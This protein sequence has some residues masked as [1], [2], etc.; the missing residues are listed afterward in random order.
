MDLQGFLEPACR[1]TV[2]GLGAVQYLE[3][4][5]LDASFEESVAADGA[6]H[7]EVPLTTGAWRTL[8]YL[9]GTGSWTEQMARSVQGAHY[10]VRIQLSLQGD[11]PEHRE[12]VSRMKGRRFLLRVPANN[13]DGLLIGTAERP[14]RFESA[15][16]S[17]SDDG[18][19]RQQTLT[20]SGVAL[21]PSPAYTPTF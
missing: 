5:R 19:S 12:E 17:G 10:A 18:G 2:P 13:G 6:Q 7:Q 20:F 8:Q 3:V 15:F 1:L 11:T 16:D 21:R 4:D 14:L 9:P